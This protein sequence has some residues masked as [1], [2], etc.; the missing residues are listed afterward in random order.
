[1][2]QPIHLIGSPNCFSIP[3][4]TPYTFALVCR[5]L[6]MMCVRGHICTAECICCRLRDSIYTY[7]L[8][9]RVL[10]S[11]IDLTCVSLRSI[12]IYIYVC[13]HS[14][15]CVY[16]SAY[17]HTVFI[18]V[19]GMSVLCSSFAYLHTPPTRMHL[20]L[21]CMRTCIGGSIFF[22]VCVCVF[23]CSDVVRQPRRKHRKPAARG[24]A[25]AP[26]YISREP[27]FGV[28]YEVLS[29]SIMLGTCIRHAYVYTYV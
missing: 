22:D 24:P 23:A 5:I 29:S 21:M 8:Y 26:G 20:L 13:I 12:Y 2:S 17:M 7:T 16:T 10:F 6:C 25:V 9:A 3:P 4:N 19:S 14:Y 1:M 27:G 15:V 28:S 11:Y 18:Y